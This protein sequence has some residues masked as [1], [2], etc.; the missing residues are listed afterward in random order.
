MII[1]NL[2]RKSKKRDFIEVMTKFYI[3]HLKLESSRFTLHL[4]IK[5]GQLKE[6]G[7]NGVTAH[8]GKEIVVCLDSGISVQQLMLTLAHEMVHVKQIATG[9]LSYAVVGDVE[10]VKWCGKDANDIPYLERPWE[11]QA[12]A[13]QE[14]L[15]RTL[16]Q[17]FQS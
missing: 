13:R 7:G 14:I 17:C 11:L 2:I 15:V 5:K 10:C 6:T 1:N 12:F 8:D 16:E 4:M 9:R 3:K